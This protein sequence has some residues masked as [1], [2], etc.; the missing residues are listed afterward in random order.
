[1]QQQ[2][3][4]KQ[5]DVVAVLYFVVVSGLS[6]LGASIRN[7]NKSIVN[8]HGDKSNANGSGPFLK[9]Q[10]YSDYSFFLIARILSVPLLKS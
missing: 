6:K 10:N 7:T 8:A 5:E 1:M 9:Y 3:S 2:E 4:A